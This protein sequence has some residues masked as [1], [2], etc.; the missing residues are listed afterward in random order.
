MITWNNEDY[1]MHYGIP[2]RS[3]RYK[4]GS[5]KNPYHHGQSLPIGFT[6]KGRLE[7][8]TKKKKIAESTVRQLGKVQ[9]EY[10][11]N[12]TKFGKKYYTGNPTN[13][14][15]QR[16]I[17][18]ARNRYKKDVA[19]YTKKS[20]KLRDKISD[21]SLKKGKDVPDNVIKKPTDKE[22]ANIITSADAKKVLKYKKYL[23]NNEL[24]MAIDRINKEKT[25][26]SMAAEDS[27][28]GLKKFE[29]WINRADR[30][31]TSAE[32]TYGSYQK[33]SKIYN[34]LSGNQNKTN[35]KPSSN[36]KSPDL[37]DGKKYTI[38]P[39]DNKPKPKKVGIMRR[40]TRSQ[41][42]ARNYRNR[43]R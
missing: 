4:W 28:K 3:G 13:R 35:I 38:N 39:S 36:N 42:F 43:K 5:G 2:K 25:L 29:K 6:K 26:K 22:K 7:R 1:L 23:S 9:K 12:P 16:D 34:S 24:Q 40:E 15:M 32:K 27:E 33:F 30:V 41:R 37:K 20:D 11:Q 18:K 21:K 19:K 17:D 31:A 10:D 14:Q 8:Y